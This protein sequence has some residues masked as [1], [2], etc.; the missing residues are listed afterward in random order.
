MQPLIVV[1]ASA[2]P[3]RAQERRPVDPDGNAKGDAA[4]LVDQLQRDIRL[5]FVE[6][7]TGVGQHDVGS[8]DERLLV[9]ETLASPGDGGEEAGAGD[10][11][12]HG[13][14]EGL[15]TGQEELD[16]LG[17]PPV[18]HPHARHPRTLLQLR[19]GLGK[20]MPRRGRGE[21][22]KGRLRTA[23]L[24]LDRGSHCSGPCGR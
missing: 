24:S 19:H 11:V 23:R 6:L 13:P 20:A 5:W 3:D 1:L 21:G 8:R 14:Y 17:R 2:T 12:R 7:L 4:R 9:V 22:R 18:L 10:V 15:H 16:G